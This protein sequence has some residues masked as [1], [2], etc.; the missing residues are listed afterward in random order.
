MKKLWDHQV[1]PAIPSLKILTILIGGSMSIRYFTYLYDH[2][3][4]FRNYYYY[5]FAVETAKT[6]HHDLLELPN[7]EPEI[8]ICQ[9]YEDKHGGDMV[10]HSFSSLSLHHQMSCYEGK[11][12]SHLFYFIFS[13]YNSVD[14]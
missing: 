11:V 9:K 6:I 4:P 7:I 5:Q 3:P 12:E 8:N 2:R 14:Y 10:C 13:S 1:H